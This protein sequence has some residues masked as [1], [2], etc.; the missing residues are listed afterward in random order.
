MPDDYRISD[1]TTIGTVSNDDLMEISAVNLASESGYSSMKIPMTSLADKIVNGIQFASDLQTNSK[2]IVGAINEV[3]QGGGVWTDLT[4]T[5]EAGET[6]LT[7]VDSSITTSSTIDFYTDVFGVNPT[8]VVV[9][10]G[11][12]VLTFESRASDLDVKVRIS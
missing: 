12:I 7:F 6:T 11:Q 2:T 5:L 8:N 9:S 10:T 3:A 4:D 1:L